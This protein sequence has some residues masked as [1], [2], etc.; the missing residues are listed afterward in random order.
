MAEVAIAAASFFE[1][2]DTAESAGPDAI[3]VLP[4]IAL[5]TC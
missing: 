4:K 2:R 3:G 1:K 5:R